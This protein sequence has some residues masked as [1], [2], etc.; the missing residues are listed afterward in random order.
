[1]N[2]KIALFGSG[3][4]VLLLGS[5]FVHSFSEEERVF[6]KRIN[7][8]E[9][10][11]LNRNLKACLPTVDLSI[12]LAEKTAQPHRY[13]QFPEELLKSLETS[14]EIFASAGVQLKI[15][16]IKRSR[17]PP[18]W[19]EITANQLKGVPVAPKY[20]T[21]LAYRQ[22]E[23]SLS[24]Q[25]ERV[26]EGIIEK[27]P[28]NNRTIYLVFLQ[29]VKMTY[30]HRNTDRKSEV[31]SIPTGGLSLPSYLFEN[32]IPGRIRGAITICRDQGNIG[33]TIA[34]ELG[35]KLMNVSHEY[36]EIDPQFEIRAKGGL[37]VYGT[38]TD[39]PA[40]KVGRWQKER[41]H[42]SPW[43]YTEPEKGHRKWN[44]DYRENGH[45]YDPI[46]GHHVVRFGEMEI[47]P[48]PIAGRGAKNE[49]TKKGG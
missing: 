38:G 21:Y 48:R 3:I 4:L 37:M 8:L 13:V 18:S 29:E 9:L 28:F 35:H 44:P 11:S 26:L 12:Y 45:Y 33:R 19:L 17:V 30:F 6:Y 22:E 25:A 43:I 7:G 41:L 47:P 46:Y 27:E 24:E 2:Q 39:I 10:A 15:R 34:H 49:K 20:N 14:R 36:R 23:W 32:R 1:M 16:S 40:G 31:R 5:K 42:L